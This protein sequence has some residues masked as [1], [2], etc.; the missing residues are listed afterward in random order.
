[1]SKKRQLILYIAMSL[2]GYIA[3]PNDDLS[4]LSLVE[5]AKYLLDT[6]REKMESLRAKLRSKSMARSKMSSKNGYK[7]PKRFK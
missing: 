6:R 3:K 7:R 2:D 5:K 4:F 1:M